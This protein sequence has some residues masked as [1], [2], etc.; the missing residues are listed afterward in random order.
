[1]EP[2]V[3]WDFRE[4]LEP[5]LGH[6]GYIL[7]QGEGLRPF[8]ARVASGGQVAMIDVAPDSTGLNPLIIDSLY[9][10]FRLEARA[11][12]IRACG[13]CW[14]ARVPAEDGSGLTD[15]VAI[16]LEHRD[17][18][19]TVVVCTYARDGDEIHFHEPISG[20]GTRHV[21]GDILFC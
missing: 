17:A 13:V 15:A 16:G 14:D 3:R 18:Q 8:G 2:N 4:L 1:M 10:T 6:A 11:G 12:T 21:F 5:M 7:A 19:P 20:L 9:A